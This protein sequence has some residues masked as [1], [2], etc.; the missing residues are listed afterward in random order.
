MHT[1]LSLGLLERQPKE[2]NIQQMSRDLAAFPP[3][4]FLC[5]SLT[6]NRS[7][8]NPLLQLDRSLLL[9]GESGGGG[10]WVPAC[11]LPLMTQ[12]ESSISFLAQTVHAWFS[13]RTVVAWNTLTNRVLGLFS[14]RPKPEES[15]A[16]S[17]RRRLL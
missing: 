3:V 12:H 10:S 7:V 5:S 1:L 13:W 6:L 15:G 9:L 11:S 8:R 2:A 17:T 16:S 14:A 4:P